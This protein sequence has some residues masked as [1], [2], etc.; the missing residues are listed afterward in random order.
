MM[1]AGKAGAGDFGQHLADHAAQ[2]VLGEDVVA[3]QIFSHMPA[4]PRCPARQIGAVTAPEKEVEASV[5]RCLRT[6][7][8]G[9]NRQG[10]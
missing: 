2:R 9:A 7:P 5:A 1:L 4:N 8:Y 3:D 10:L 6:P